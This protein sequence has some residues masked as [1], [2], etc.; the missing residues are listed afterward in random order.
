MVQY[1]FE[2]FNSAPQLILGAH[3]LEI[4]TKSNVAHK[5]IFFEKRTSYKLCYIELALMQS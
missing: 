4:E 5:P 2:T 3:L 1:R